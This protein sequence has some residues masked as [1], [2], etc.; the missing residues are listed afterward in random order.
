MLIKPKAGQAG[1][2]Q[3]ALYY[4]WMACQKFI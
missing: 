3:E 2:R 1:A 4:P